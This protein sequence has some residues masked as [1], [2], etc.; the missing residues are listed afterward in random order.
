[1]KT[2]VDVVFRHVDCC[3]QKKGKPKT[4]GKFA[5]DPEATMAIP[6]RVGE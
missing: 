2:H 3:M 1:M 6:A 4:A 5:R